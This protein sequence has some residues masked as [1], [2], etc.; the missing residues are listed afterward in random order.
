[1]KNALLPTIFDCISI[2]LNVSLITALTYCSLDSFSGVMASLFGNT[3][4][5]SSYSFSWASGFFAK[6][7]NAHKLPLDV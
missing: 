1:M 5:I 2:Y 4:L 6:Q 3:C 7:Y